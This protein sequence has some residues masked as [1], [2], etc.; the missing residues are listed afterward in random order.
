LNCKKSFIWKR[1]YNKKYREKHW[2]NLWVKEGYSIRQ[3]AYYSKHSHSKL[4]RII[5]Y[6]IA[7]DPP[8]TNS[9]I[10]YKYIELDGT[11]FHK[12]GCLIC[13]IDVMS[14]KIIDTV[15]VKKENYK[16]T[17]PWLKELSRKGLYPKYIALDGERSVIQAVKDV[18]P[19]ITI[20][21]CLYHIQREGL[22][23][24][25]TYP[26]T[27]AGKDLRVILGSLCAI[28]TEEEKNEF[29]ILFKQWDLKYRDRIRKLPTSDIGSKDL[30]KTIRLV[31][32][33]LPNM[34]KYLKD[35]NIPSTTNLLEGFYS[36]LKSDYLRHRGLTEE[37]KRQYLK[38]Y[39]YLKRE[40]WK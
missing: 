20:Q 9:Y 19:E 5:N 21:R 3:L 7:Q 16:N 31:Q 35:K 30:K 40:N 14:K 33:A 1:V 37:K 18:W 12:N 6:W 10:E 2:F 24:L 8:A 15:Y 38:W 22:R 29:I 39:C 13:I 34:F 32:N 27:Q 11:Y 28:R 25:R 26:K 23:W 36:Q 17:Y 4:K